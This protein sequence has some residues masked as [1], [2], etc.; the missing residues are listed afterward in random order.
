MMSGLDVHYDLGEGH[1]LVGRRMPDLDLTTPNGPLRLYTLL[2][3]AR[4]VFLNFGMPGGADI[5][6][7]ADRVP[8]IDAV[9]DGAWELP[10][11]GAVTAPTGVLIRPDGY[12]A[13]VGDSTQLGLSDALTTWFGPPAA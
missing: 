4:P 8:S 10:A 7:W 12:V 5:T 6:L 13:W 1:P 11:L 3:N 9:Y 2:H